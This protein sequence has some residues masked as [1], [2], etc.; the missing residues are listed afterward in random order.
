MAKSKEQKKA[1]LDEYKS[2]LKENKGYITVDTE[3]IDAVTLTELKLKL[4][5]LGSNVTVVKN[6][7]FKI[8]LNDEDQPVE[9]TNFDYQTAVIP[10][11]DDPTQIAK[12][13]KEVQED[14]EEFEAK[15]G[16]VEGKYLDAKRVMELAEIPSREE[17][18][19]K[20]VG[21]MSSPAR[22]FVTVT[23][24]ATRGF[25]QILQQLSEREE[26]G[27]TE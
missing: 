14:T 25:T 11:N 27:E 17:L 16:V 9:T 18:L 15:Y 20:L 5:E 19:A 12:M 13:V 4:K 23:N 22:G 6:K 24:G 1:L 2:L 8:A 3:K 7:I 21:S 10:Y 26:T